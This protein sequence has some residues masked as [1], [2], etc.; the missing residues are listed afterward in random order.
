M[1]KFVL[2]TSGLHY[3]VRTPG[4]ENHNEIIE[5]CEIYLTRQFSN[6]Y[7][8]SS[9]T[10]YWYFFDRKEAIRFALTWT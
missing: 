6:S 5:W 7:F 9:N 2:Y 8:G 4:Y 3:K 1:S 10:T